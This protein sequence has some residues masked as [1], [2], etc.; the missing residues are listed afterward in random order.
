MSKDAAKKKAPAGAPAKVTAEQLAQLQKPEFWQSRLDL[1]D[2]LY[3]KQCE[4]YKA[5]AEPI[6]VTLPDGK[7]MEATAWSTTPLEIAKRISNSLPDK[8]VVA[9][10]DDVLWDLSRPLETSCAIELLDW[11]YPEAREVFWHSSAHVLGAAMEKALNCK[12]SIGPPLEDGGFFYEGDV[13]RSVSE[14]DYPMLEACAMELVKAKQPY[15]R[16]SLSKDDALQMF[17]YNP[18]KSTILAGKVP[19]GSYCTVYRCGNLIDPCRGPH[20]PDTGRVKCFAVTRN[21]S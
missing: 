8:I 18:F 4:E 5:R 17:G 6:T 1:F 10:V 3:A 9:K 15:Q 14:L 20:L 7:T 19:E 12:L 21:S 13:G 11:D 2:R 16:L